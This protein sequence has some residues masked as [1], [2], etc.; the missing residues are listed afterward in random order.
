MHKPSPDQFE[1]WRANPITEWFM[2]F[3][4]AEMARTKQNFQEQAWE[5]H[6]DGIAHATHRERY[7]TLDWVRGLDMAAIEATMGMQDGE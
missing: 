7:E 3:L 4:A 1:G 6:G 5:G 2:K